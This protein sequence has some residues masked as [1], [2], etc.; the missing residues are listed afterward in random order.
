MLVL[1]V[2]C[3]GGGAGVGTGAICRLSF[4]VCRSAAGWVGLVGWSMMDGMKRWIS[5]RVRTRSVLSMTMTPRGSGMYVC[6][7]YSV[8]DRAKEILYRVRR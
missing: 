3:T 5:S 4:V 2:R 7:D 8:A 6:M 1:D